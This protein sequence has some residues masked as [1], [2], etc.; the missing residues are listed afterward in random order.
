MHPFCDWL[1]IYQ[2]HST[3]VPVVNDGRIFSVDAD[4]VVK[5]ETGSKIKHKGSFETSVN[6]VSDGYRVSISGNVGRFGRADNLFGYSVA[7]CVQIASKL[8]AVFGLPPFTDSAP[9]P[10]V[11]K[12]AALPSAEYPV[13]RM[14]A[15]TKAAGHEGFAATGAVIT[16]VDLTCNFSA[17]TSQGCTQLMRYLAG[18]KMR[19]HPPRSYY[20]SGV[21]WGEKSKYWY[22]KIYDKASDYIRHRSAD[23][24]LHDA[25]LYQFIKESGTGRL[26]VELKS[27]Y[28]RQNN[29]W[30]ITQWD[31]EMQAKVY[32]LFTDPIN[33]EVN[34]DSFLEI[35]GR[36]GELALAW[37]DGAD[38]KKRLSKNTY[39][40][41][42]RELLGYN[43]DIAVVSNIE[44]L[45]TKINV[46]N[47]SPLLMPDWYTLP[48]VDLIEFAPLEDS[49]SP[50]QAPQQRRA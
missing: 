41:Y 39:Y 15:Y 36:A 1:S 44:R 43:I 24:T 12:L 35:P 34:V 30:R 40:K 23:H 28:L 48:P 47:L 49:T 9:R 50:L 7:E 45:K 5:W 13:A 31:N 22:A 25:R 38:L 29:L 2:V 20:D 16:R 19:Q 17:G 14:A 8:A 37:R 33:G 10:I 18:F 27:R 26:E 42:R 46:V 21:S 11:A 32:A 4:G 6:V 3:P